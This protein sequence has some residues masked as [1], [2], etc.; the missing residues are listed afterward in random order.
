MV[1]ESIRYCL[2]KAYALA[3]T[4]RPGPC[5]L[6]IPLDVQGA[7]VEAE[8]LKGYDTS[9]NMGQ[10]VESHVMP[11]WLPGIVDLLKKAKRP[12]LYAGNGIRLAHG[13]GALQKLIHQ[14]NIPIV[15]CWDSID[16][17]DNEN[18]CFCGRGGTMGDRAGNFAVQNSDLLLCVG[19]R[20]NIYQVGYNVDT[21]A[22]AATTVVVDIDSEELRKKTIRADIPICADAAYFLRVVSLAM[23]GTQPRDTS[24]WLQQCQFWKTQYP[25]VRNEQRNATGKVNVYAFVDSLSRVLPAG[26]NYQIGRASCRERV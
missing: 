3:I 20:L 17:V 24:L 15:T 21:W 9:N 8:E 22:R 19:T 11:P 7:Y 26:A 14:L 16:L 13:T 23:E 12:V 5:W 4:G 18:P 6:D 10:P 1:P 2:E 25:V